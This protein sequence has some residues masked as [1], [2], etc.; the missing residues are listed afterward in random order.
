MMADFL[1]DTSALS[2]QLLLGNSLADWL[3]AGIVAIAV[4]FGLWIVRRLIAARYKKHSTVRARPTP[5][6]L[7][8]YLLGNT[9][10]FLF[11]ALALDAG[12]GKPDVAAI[13]L[14]HVVRQRRA[15]V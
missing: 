10:Q 7:I 6:R 13:A 15:D 14:Q 8:A 4:W 9:K 3:M 5:V 1:Q 2:E 12:A 11:F